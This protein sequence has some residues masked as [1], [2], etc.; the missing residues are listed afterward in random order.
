MDEVT[1]PV[2]E[3]ERQVPKGSRVILD[4]PAGPF[5]VV[6]GLI[7]VYSGYLFYHTLKGLNKAKV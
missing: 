7:F 5:L 6:D 3:A 2:F 1:G 4:L